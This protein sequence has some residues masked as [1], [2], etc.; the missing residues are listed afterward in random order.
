MDQI[1]EWVA[2]AGVGFDGDAIHTYWHLYYFC[3]REQDKANKILF[4]LLGSEAVD[5]TAFELTSSADYTVMLF[6]VVAIICLLA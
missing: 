4:L 6:I 5:S 2:V 1:I 3:P